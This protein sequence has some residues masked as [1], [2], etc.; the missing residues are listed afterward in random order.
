MG[1]IEIAPL[2][3]PVERVYGDLRA[4]LE[5]TGRPIGG[6]DLFIA[7]RSVALGLILVTDNERDFSRIDELRC[8]NWLR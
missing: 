6:N 1:A 2:D 3:T 7:A 5:R 8:E 4:K